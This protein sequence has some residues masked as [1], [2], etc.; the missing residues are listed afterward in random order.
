MRGFLFGMMLGAIAGVLYAPSTG[1]R[2]RA[3]IR[4][5][6]SE[7]STRGTDLVNTSREQLRS[8]IDDVTML[9]QENAGP[10]R[11]RVNQVRDEVRNRI[12]EVRGKVEERVDAM[13]GTS[14]DGRTEATESSADNMRQSA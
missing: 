2:T 4:D 14:N 3:L 10:M 7:Y 6:Y 1:S 12:S 13:R 5:K 9:V 11:E 8:T